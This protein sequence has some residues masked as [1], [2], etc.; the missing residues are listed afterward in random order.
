MIKKIL[1]GLA[2]I[3]T[4]TACNENF[5]DWADPQTNPEPTVVAF[6]DGSVSEVGVIDMAA[7]AD[8]QTAVKVC[9]IQAPTASKEGFA[10]TYKI[11]LG[12]SSYDVSG[13]GEM[14]VAELSKYLT[15]N[16]ILRPVDS[17]IAATVEMWLS[18]G[19]SAIKTATS[20]QFN[21]TVKPEAPV[22]ESA[23]YVTGTPN[24]WNN[25]DKT[26][27][28]TNGGGDVYANPVFTCLIPSDGSDIEFKITPESGIGGDWSECLCS[29]DEE[30]KFLMHNVGGNFFIP[31][32]ADA[33]FV[34][35]SF[36]MMN[37]TWK[38]EYLAFTKFVYFIG[39]TDGWVKSEQRLESPAFDG[40]YTGYIYIA[41]PNGWGIAGKFQRVAGSWDDQINAGNTTCKNGV[42]GSDN[43][44]FDAEGVYYITLDLVNNTISATLIKNMNLVG[45]FN[46]WNQADDAQQMT[47]D[48]ENLCFVKTGAGVNANGWKF[49]ANNEWG[50]NLGGTTANLVGNGDNLNVAGST[51]KLYP[52]R[53]SSDNIYATVE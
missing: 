4:L 8:G 44:E 41:D 40:V 3:G 49:T 31:G 25:A 46:G 50:I 47:W 33:K 32:N 53:T 17:Q 45:D 42:H 1:F 52:C 35:L 22:I 13:N 43:F 23:Y 34:K 15:D 26:L 27:E 28:L 37:M 9:N 29:S 30:G 11:N 24:G 20:S 6:G 7:I 16:G 12:T 5:E 14:L 39:S 18:N 48:A 21:V 51:I 2:C 38:Y 36:D 10:P 19:V